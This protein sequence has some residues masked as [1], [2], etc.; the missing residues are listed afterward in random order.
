M[1][2]IDFTY[3]DNLCQ[4]TPVTFIP[5]LLSN[6][7][8]YFWDFGDNTQNTQPSAS[9]AYAE[10]NEYDVTLTITNKFGCTTSITK[11]I[12]I[13]KNEFVG[14]L[15][16]GDEVCSG[17]D[18]TIILIPRIEYNN[19]GTIHW[20]KDNITS[21][22]IN[23]TQFPNNS[24]VIQEPGIYFAKVIG[25][26]GCETYKDIDGVAVNFYPI[27]KIPVIKGQTII[28]DNTF[29]LSVDSANNT[30]Y[31]WYLD[32]Q[33]L[34]EWD[35]HTNINHT[36]DS[37]QP[38]Y[39]VFE[40]EANYRWGNGSICT[41]KSSK[42]RVY[43]SPD[44]EDPIIEIVE[45]TCAP[46]RAI[47]R[48][49]N[50]IDGIDY[51]WS[52]GQKGIQA[53]Y[54]HDGPI[55]VRAQYNICYKYANINLPSNIYAHTS[56]FPKG[57]YSFC[58]NNQTASIQPPYIWAERWYW[59]LNENK[60][61]EGENSLVKEILMANIYETGILELYVSNGYCEMLIKQVELTIN[62]CDPDKCKLEIKKVSQFECNKFENTGSNYFSFDLELYNDTNYTTNIFI[63]NSNLFTLL[64][65]QYS[66]QPGD[67]TLTISF[68][69]EDPE[70]NTQLILNQG[71][72]ELNIEIPLLNC[73]KTFKINNKEFFKS[74]KKCFEHF[75]NKASQDYITIVP[76]PAVG[77]TEIISSEV[78]EKGSTIT[79][80]D[81]VGRTVFYT[82][83]TNSSKSL[84]LDIS[85]LATGTYQ[86]NTQTKKG[87]FFSKLIVK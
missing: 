37:L 7:L 76:N 39:Y 16:K 51:Y 70:T 80:T 67:N 59:I 23:I 41:S 13:L 65:N 73:L 79:I 1:Q 30:T 28:C 46:Y 71:Y 27:L 20:F 36:I 56:E 40:V 33:H 77:Y 17:E 61:L 19:S 11:R 35:G 64:Q 22:P 34:T 50:P 42:F 54:V 74:F 21:E 69:I 10:N 47:V 18:N 4:H 9:I 86:V 60:I 53:T 24:I 81:Y 38:G 48:V 57:C 31:K 43:K 26:N 32:G 62:N 83:V 82:N 58:L 8:Q 14:S 49:V 75:T 66:I 12:Y 44:I 52:N 68:Y 3:T 6:D 85:K 25:I 87:I 72:I 45:V 55:L 63:D 29:Y 15:H 84:I 78:F 5:S 2:T